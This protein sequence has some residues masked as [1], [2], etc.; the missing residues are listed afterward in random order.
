MQRAEVNNYI[1]TGSGKMYCNRAGHSGPATSVQAT[2]AL[3]GAVRNAL[4][5]LA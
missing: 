4:A 3:H 1:A 5:E 2:G